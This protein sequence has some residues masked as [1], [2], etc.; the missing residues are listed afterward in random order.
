MSDLRSGTKRRLMRLLSNSRERVRD[1][2][3]E[4]IDQPEIEH[5]DADDKEEARHEELR[6][7]HGVHQR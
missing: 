7:D 3:D 4:Q 6:V 1:H 5:H 2:S